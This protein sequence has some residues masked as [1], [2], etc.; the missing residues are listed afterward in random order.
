MNFTDK[1]KCEICNG[2]LIL[3]KVYECKRCRVIKATNDN[4]PKCPHCDKSMDKMEEE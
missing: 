4:Y 2:D 3:A 1:A